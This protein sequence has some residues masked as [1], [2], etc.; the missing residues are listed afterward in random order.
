MVEKSPV[1][2][3]DLVNPDRIMDKVN[4]G[5]GLYWKYVKDNDIKTARLWKIQKRFRKDPSDDNHEQYWDAVV[6]PTFFDKPHFKDLSTEE[7]LLMPTVFAG[8]LPHNFK[9]NQAVGIYQANKVLSAI[10]GQGADRSDRLEF[11]T[12]LV[13]NYL[14]VYKYWH[15]VGYDVD[16]V[17][18][19]AI[20]RNRLTDRIKEKGA[21]RQLIVNYHQNILIEDPNPVSFAKLLPH[22][23]LVEALAII[24]SD[25]VGRQG[26]AEIEKN[27]I[28]DQLPPEIR[29]KS[30]LTYFLEQNTSIRKSDD[31][32]VKKILRQ[33]SV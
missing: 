20:L 4:R 7:K 28:F 12:S 8:E 16:I 3:K 29:G 27:T 26:I 15:E 14:R 25:K 31:F 19:S 6:A 30:T 11:L 32:Y 21:L 22:R 18:A 33:S 17:I 10:K 24:S 23:S 1:F 2:Q 9:I 5:L 13:D